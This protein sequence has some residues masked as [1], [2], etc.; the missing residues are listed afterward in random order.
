MGKKEMI[1]G[2]AAA[3]AVCAFL[4]PVQAAPRAEL[5]DPLDWLYP[6]SKIGEARAF[7]ATEVPANGVAEVNV[8]FND[9]EIGREVT[10]S[11][12]RRDAEWFRF[13][14]VPVEVNTGLEGGVERASVTNRFVSRDAPFRVYD[15]LEPLKGGSFVP[16]AKTAALRFR[17]RAFGTKSG[18]VPVS[19][20]FA[21]GKFHVTRTFTVNV[22][23]AELPP[24]GKASFRY[25]NWMNYDSM[26]LCH[27]LKPWSPEHLEMIRRYV[28]LAAY[29]RQNMSLVPLFDDPKRIESFVRL[30][31]ES[32]IW[33]LEGAHLAGF[34]THKW[35]APAF[36]PRGS[37]NLTTSAEGERVL[38]KKATYV[39]DVIRRNGWEARWY[40]HVADEP[41]EHN[42]SEYRKTCVLV[43]KY[44]PGVKLTDAVES[45]DMPGA[46]EA[47]CPKNRYYE[48]NRARFEALRVSPTN[49][50]WCYT[51]MFP[52]GRWLNR[53][54]DNEL[55]RPTLLPWG[56]A[57]FS[58]D[59]YLHW[60]YNQFGPKNDPLR[61]NISRDEHMSSNLPPGDRNIVYAGTDGPWP[62][63]RLE[64]MR[65]GFEDCELLKILSARDKSAA[66][67]L[68][69]RLVRGFGDYTT[70]LGEY[71]SVR[72]ALLRAVAEER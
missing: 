27:G 59:G 5:T 2:F 46:L 44:M 32:G 71:W 63:V 26:A 8:L 16:K 67:A 69:R 58:L 25:T 4:G 18:A 55:V 61:T 50:I 36:V 1:H 52:G 21:Q 48:E 38:A 39:A 47:Y 68:V 20:T 37:T 7:E 56:C 31:E 40:Q 70:D 62:S 6:D 54:L 43:H 51:C 22:H 34:S 14:D 15:A 64:A 72:K 17:L 3:L 13:V 24:V 57:A 12:D 10:F 9:L 28:R 11:A 53:L 19:L 30:L 35:G 42:L 65:Q 45:Y 49:E 41:S 33:Y 29:G 60:G 66:D 23:A